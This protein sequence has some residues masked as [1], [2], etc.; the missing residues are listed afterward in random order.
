M[1]TPYF[2]VCGFAKTSVEVPPQ[3]GN[4]IP[5]LV[6]LERSDMREVTT[7]EIVKPYAD[8]E[9]YQL[10][11]KLMSLTSNF[12]V[13]A[14]ARRQRETANDQ[15]EFDRKITTD[16]NRVWYKAMRGI[17]KCSNRQWTAEEFARRKKGF[18]TSYKRDPEFK[19]KVQTR[20]IEARMRRVAI[21]LL[22]CPISLKKFEALYRAA[23]ELCVTELTSWLEVNKRVLIEDVAD[24]LKTLKLEE[25]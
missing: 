5:Y 18:V 23:D 22:A 25:K 11:V 21:D 12:D 24:E 16:V 17:E 19:R 13:S 15:R 9:I 1:K 4:G 14:Y 10:L 6:A 20:A 2:F 8:P 3:V 7:R